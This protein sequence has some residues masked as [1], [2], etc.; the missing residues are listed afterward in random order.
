MKE[1]I[2]TI[3][4]KKIKLSLKKLIFK[5]EKKECDFI[6]ALIKIDKYHIFFNGRYSNKAKK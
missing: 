2:L 1:K 3:M 4:L 5:S 6:R